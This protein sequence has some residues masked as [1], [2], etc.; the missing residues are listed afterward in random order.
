M[1]VARMCELCHKFKIKRTM[2]NDF[3]VELNLYMNSERME[4]GGGYVA[5]T[6]M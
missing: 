4:G 3:A 6:T 1:V 2:R 5:C